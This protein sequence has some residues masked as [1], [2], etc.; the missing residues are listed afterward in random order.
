M[1]ANY[2]SKDYVEGGVVVTLFSELLDGDVFIFQNDL[3]NLT[4]PF[5]MYQVVCG[6][7]GYYPPKRASYPKNAFCDR[8]KV[9][10]I[11]AK[12]VE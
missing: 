3:K 1:L 11:N 8:L 4:P 9:I 5:T 10:L 6:R 7:I 2:C 12:G